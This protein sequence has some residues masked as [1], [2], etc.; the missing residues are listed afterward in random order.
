MARLYSVEDL[1][2][3]K[4]LDYAGFW[5]LSNIPLRITLDEW[6]AMLDDCWPP[7]DG[8][9]VFAHPL[10]TLRQWLS[11][12]PHL[13]Y[14]ELFEVVLRR[15]GKSKRFIPSKRDRYRARKDVLA[16]LIKHG[17]VEI[18]EPKTKDPS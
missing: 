12:D 5:Y 1:S 16:Y 9:K 14:H 13:D 18:I 6:N 11:W 8:L 10:F 4:F 17:C 15:G 2:G 3:D 7:I